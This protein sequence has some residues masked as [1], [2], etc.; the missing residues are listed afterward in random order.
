[1][2]KFGNTKIK[3]LIKIQDTGTYKGIWALVLRM[4]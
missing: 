3:I 1:M 2:D 4:K